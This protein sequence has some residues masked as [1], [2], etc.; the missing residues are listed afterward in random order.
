M[1]NRPMTHCRLAPSALALIPLALAA[2]VTAGC[3][4]NHSEDAIRQAY[5]QRQQ[6]AEAAAKSLEYVRQGQRF[7]KSKKLDKAI[8]QYKL[9]VQ[10]YS[11]SPFAWNNLGRLYMQRQENMEAAQAFEQAARLSPSDPVPVHNMGALYESMGWENDAQRYYSE[12]L[13][14]DPNYVPSLRRSVWLDVSYNK[15]TDLTEQR[16]KRALAL[17]K[18]PKWQELLLRAKVR[19]HD[20]S[21]DAIQKSGRSLGSAPTDGVGGAER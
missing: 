15:I 17:N 18:D 12:A 9:A 21:T 16:L 4:T 11:E 2:A 3:K 13:Q 1:M 7:E 14:R 5:V 20:G 6:E 10:T 8:E 19:M